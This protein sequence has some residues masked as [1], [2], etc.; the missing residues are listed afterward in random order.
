LVRLAHIHGE[1][2]KTVNA[3]TVRTAVTARKVGSWSVQVAR[4][5]CVNT[6]HRRMRAIR[7]SPYPI[8]RA[9]FTPER[10]TGTLIII[11]IRSLLEETRP[12]PVL[13]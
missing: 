13:P 2:L 5:A 8:P 4:I 12:M 1:L 10:L 3:S 7:S 6:V 11:G 9:S